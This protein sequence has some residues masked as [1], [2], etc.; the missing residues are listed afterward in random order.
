MD[1]WRDGWTDA[2]MDG[3]MDGG[4]DAGMDREVLQTEG[5]SL[6]WA[7]VGVS[8]AA[9]GDGLDGVTLFAGE[10]AFLSRLSQHG[11]LP[12]S[13][14]VQRVRSVLPTRQRSKF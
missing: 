1:R 12:T 9:P 8:P 7:G 4:R 6:C 10:F 14:P 5:R 2:G 13:A 3:D 11:I